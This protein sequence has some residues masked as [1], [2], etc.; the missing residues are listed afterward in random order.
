MIERQ[1]QRGKKPCR[2]RSFARFFLCAFPASLAI[3]FAGC[4][5]RDSSAFELR[6]G[7][8]VVF[9][10]DTVIERDQ[11][12][13]WLEVMLASRFPG[14]NITFRNLGWSADTPEG[15]SRTL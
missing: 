5:G 4:A 3:V 12:H 15:A 9:L 13:G 7:D 10:G 14:K 2:A 1:P 8:R 11:Y 6:D